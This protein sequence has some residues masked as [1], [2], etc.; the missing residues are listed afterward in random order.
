MEG[1]RKKEKKKEQKNERKN[2]MKEE[3][4][5]KEEGKELR[6]RSKRKENPTFPWQISLFLK[7][8]FLTKTVTF[9]PKMAQ[10]KVIT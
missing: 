6:G 2:E 4:H 3:N 8:P 7:I 9:G 10:N 5:E 1:K